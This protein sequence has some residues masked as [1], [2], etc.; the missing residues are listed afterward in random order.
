MA[1]CGYDRERQILMY[2]FRAPR[3]IFFPDDL[4]HHLPHAVVIGFRMMHSVKDML[5]R[6]VPVEVKDPLASLAFLRLTP[7]R[8]RRSIRT[9]R[10]FVFRFLSIFS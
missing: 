1:E 4:L 6:K 2:L 8:I 10:K 5:I 9:Q 7:Y 3:S